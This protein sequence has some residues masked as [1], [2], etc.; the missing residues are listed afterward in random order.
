MNGVDKLTYGELNVL[1]ENAEIGIQS[2]L[3]KCYAI[4][5]RT[6]NIDK[7]DA[8]EILIK[9]LA[10]KQQIVFA[11]DIRHHKECLGVKKW[12]NLAY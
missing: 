12:K 1:I 7:I 4:I 8:Y 10:R 2:Q 5:R 9:E 11:I 3:S 6:K